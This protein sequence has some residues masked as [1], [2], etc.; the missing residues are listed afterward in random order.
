MNYWSFY[1]FYLP[2]LE[3]GIT[4][5]SGSWIFWSFCSLW[6]FVILKLKQHLTSF[7]ETHCLLHLSP[8]K[9]GWKI[10]NLSLTLIDSMYQKEEEEG[11]R[12]QEKGEEEGM[13]R[14]IRKH[15]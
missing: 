2:L 15:K 8:T 1:N 13:E 12:G 7:Y 14:V 10:L 3:F 5:V 11:G 6:K 9:C 4:F